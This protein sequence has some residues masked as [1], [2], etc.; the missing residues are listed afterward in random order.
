MTRRDTN[1]LGP[2][3]ADGAAL[4]RTLNAHPSACFLSAVQSF[5]IVSTEKQVERDIFAPFVLLFGLV[6]GSFNN[7]CIYRL[8]RGESVVWPPSHCPHCGHRLGFWDLIPVFSYLFLRGRCRYCRSKITARYAI[9]EA[10]T[11]AFFVGALLKVGVHWSLVPLFVMGCGLI[12]TFFIDLEHGIVPDATVLAV[13]GAGIV[14][15][16]VMTYGTH[17]VP[18]QGLIPRSVVGA[19]GAAGVFLAIKLIFTFVFRREAMGWGD[20][21]LAG[22]I[23]TFVSFGYPFVA[24]LLASV[25]GGFVVGISLR[26]TKVKGPWAEIPFGPF[27]V[28][29]AFAMLFAGKTLTS[30]AIALYGMPRVG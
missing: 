6:A 28:A 18:A 9:V 7:V 4:R 21:T 29:A 3:F 22:A 20:V 5:G 27:M 2:E 15:D 26:L 8:P 23:G 13:G 17:E 30:L 14:M 12:I 16:L 25:A 24:F 19:L 10:A 11:A 1:S